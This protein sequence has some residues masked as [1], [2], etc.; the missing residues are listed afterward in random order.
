MRFSAAIAGDGTLKSSAS[1]PVG[2]AN[3]SKLDLLIIQFHGLHLGNDRPLAAPGIDG[4]R[5]K[6]PLA[7]VEDA[8]EIP[9]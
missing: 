1:R 6:H 9:L 3:R 7:L 8:T 2:R 4:N 5:D